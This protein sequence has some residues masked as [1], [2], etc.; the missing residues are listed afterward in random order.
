MQNF[1]NFRKWI[2]KKWW[3]YQYLIPLKISDISLIT[4]LN[5][6]L[7]YRFYLYYMVHWLFFINTSKKEKYY[8]SWWIDSSNILENLAFDKNIEN[9]LVEN[10]KEAKLSYYFK[11]LK[12]WLIWSLIDNNY[13]F[14]SE[15]VWKLYNLLPKMNVIEKWN[16][17]EAWIELL[18][19]PYYFKWFPYK[20][21]LE[22]IKQKWRPNS[23][24]NDNLI[25]NDFLMT[26]W[27]EYIPNKKL[28]S[29][30]NFYKLYN[31]I[32]K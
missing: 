22:A 16:I 13:Y 26:W 15:E 29:L 30:N 5:F 21:I 19:N 14:F 4:T 17:I 3:L 32:I 27:L 7:L 2:Y 28:N 23:Y 8:K 11:W 20:V 9:Y 31:A 1:L 10:I 18:E 24:K 25:F 12:N 6:I